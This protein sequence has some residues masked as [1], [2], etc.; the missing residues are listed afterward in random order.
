[1]GSNV[2]QTLGALYKERRL[3]NLQ[4]L[5]FC[6]IIINAKKLRKRNLFLRD[7]AKATG[8]LR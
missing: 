7:T 6:V 2:I 8:A 5:L 1:M 4:L 3:P